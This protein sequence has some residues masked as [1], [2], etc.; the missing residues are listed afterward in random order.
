MPIINLEDTETY[1]I[2]NELNPNLPINKTEGHDTINFM[3][4]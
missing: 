4:L 1:K 3:T 2:V